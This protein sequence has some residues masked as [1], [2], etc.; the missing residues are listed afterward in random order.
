MLAFETPWAATLGRDR[1]VIAP[2]RALGPREKYGRSIQPFDAAI[3][4]HDAEPRREAVLLIPVFI[5]FF[6]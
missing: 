4:P 2:N 3:V 6:R 1:S 5:P